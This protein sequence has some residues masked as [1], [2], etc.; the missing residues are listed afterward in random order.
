MNKEDIIKYASVNFCTNNTITEKIILNFEEIVDEYFNY[1]ELDEELI[2]YEALALLIVPIADYPKS[3]KLLSQINTQKSIVLQSAIYQINEGYIPGYLI[4]KLHIYIESNIE[5]NIKS[6]LLFMLSKEISNSEK[7]T[8]ILLNK[9][10]EINPKSVLPYIKLGYI[11]IDK[12]NKLIGEE[13][14]LKGLSNIENVTNSN[15]KINYVSFNRFI[16]EN[17]IGNV[18]TDVL[19]N[20]YKSHMNE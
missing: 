17:F 5:N 10:I 1:N 20:S 19:Y 11:Y 18:M 6:A 13:Y 15:S 7:E 9:S 2:I 12:K 8:I 16:N 14:I 3:L 4:E